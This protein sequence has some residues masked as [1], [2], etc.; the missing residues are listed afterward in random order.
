[1]TEQNG[2]DVT[3][4]EPDPVPPTTLADVQTGSVVSIV[5]AIEQLFYLVGP[6]VENQETRVLLLLGGDAVI[7]VPL[8]MEVVPY[9]LEHVTIKPS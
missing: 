7:T 4:E 8:V 1:M 9:T 5:G 6:I 2:V 3:V